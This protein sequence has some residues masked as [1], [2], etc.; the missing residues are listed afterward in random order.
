[1]NRACLCDE[2]RV[3]PGTQHASINPSVIWRRQTARAI[4][5]TDGDRINILSS[6]QRYYLNKNNSLSCIISIK[7]IYL[8]GL[9]TKN[10]R[11]RSV[12]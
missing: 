9:E 8:K 7:N 11:A 3:G 4:Q 12:L 5:L 6:K 10:N 2:V 1:M